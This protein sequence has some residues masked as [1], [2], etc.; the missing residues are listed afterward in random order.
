M[1]KSFGKSKLYAVLGTTLFLAACNHVGQPYMNTVNGNMPAPPSCQAST[2]Q[3]MVGQPESAIS[4]IELTN[5]IRIVKPGTSVTMDYNASR[6]T[7]TLD[8]T[9]VISTVSC[10]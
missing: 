3:W 1:I 4:G 10:G 2:L 9:G 6:L 8:E 5:P 7:F